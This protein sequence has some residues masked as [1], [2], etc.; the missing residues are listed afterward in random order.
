MSKEIISMSLKELD[1]LQIIRDSVSR[2]ITQEQAADRIGISIRQVK[3]LVQR[4]RIEGPQG[5][6]SR[7]RGQRP[8]NAFTS[9]FRTLVISLVRDKYPDFGPTFACEKLREIHG[10]ALSAETLRKWMVEE[11]L[12]RERRRKIARIYQRRQRRPCYGELI[13]I[14]G[15]PHDWFE[16]RGPRCTLIVFIDDATSALMAL[17]FAPAETTRAYME[18]LRDYHDKYG[19]PL[20][21]YSDRHSIFRVNN[22]EREG[23]LTQFTRAIKTLGIEP[24]HA[25][26]PQAKGR[27]ERANQ[28]LQDR[29]VKE[30][31]LRNIS[32]IE[33]ANLWLSEFMK[34]YNS[35]F[36]SVPR[37]NGNAH[38]E[39]LH[40]P[41]ELNYILCYQSRRVLSKNLTFQYKTSAYQIRSEGQGYRLRHA[42]VTVCENFNGEITVLHESR[43]LGYEIYV[44]GPEPIPLDDEKSV[45]ERVDNARYNLRSKYYVKPAADHPWMTRRTQSKDD[46]KPPTLPRKKVDPDTTPK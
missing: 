32:D 21:L 26:T 12:W 28:T 17:R 20:A 27:V 35:R 4:Y 38:R 37:E 40:S 7:R 5:L 31:R 15:S 19:R 13:Q 43:P 29:L 33:S 42:I 46:V 6:V 2:Q 14:D 10:L 30:L 23:E 22:P 1:R 16:D 34:D 8:N 36:A 3:R 39:I 25:N 9:E 24:I 41:E 44:D 11:G 45:H 18:T